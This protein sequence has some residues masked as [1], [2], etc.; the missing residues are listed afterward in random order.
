MNA[1]RR[2]ILAAGIGWLAIACA[3][4][5]SV[6]KPVALSAE[7]PV[8]YP[9]EMWNQGVEGRALLRV[10]V[11]VEGGVDSVMLAESS[12]HGALDSAAMAG[13]RAMAFAPA[14][15]NGE[16]LRAWA[17]VPVRF[18]TDPEHSRADSASDS[19]PPSGES[20]GA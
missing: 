13:V 1:V 2:G 16:P 6:E 14:R 3:G 4:D 7:S 11:N 8:E 12:G 9:V 17:D 5:E 19:D 10:L 18:S 15:R 20:G